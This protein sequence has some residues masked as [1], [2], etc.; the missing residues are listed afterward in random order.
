MT[1]RE[2]I[3]MLLPWYVTGKLEASDRARVEAYLAAYP[4]M[5]SQLEMISDE[6]DATVEA[7][8]MAG[9]PSAGAL[10]RLL[11]EVDE[12]YGAASTQAGAGWLK[13]QIGRLA[14]AFD[15]PV[16]R[17]AAMAAAVVIAVQAVAIGTLS[18]GGKSPAGYQTA[19]GKSPAGYGL[20]SGPDDTEE[21]ARL[22]V[23][24]KP[25]AKL[26]DIAGLLEGIEGSIVSG[27][28]GEGLYEI[29]IAKPDITEQE[30]DK[31][32]DALGKREDL[33]GFVSVSE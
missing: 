9:A 19:G 23:S 1:E 22:L 27:P 3:E 17:Y 13:T 16:V 7:N 15:V 8:E 26:A 32:V 2:D 24:F 12:R 20:A 5:A 4:E 29:S 31:I 10:N 14:Q 33:I 28:R 6:L 11:D 25:Q 21:G 18:T 30:L